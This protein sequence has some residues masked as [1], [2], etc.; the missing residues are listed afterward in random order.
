MNFCV[1]LL[2]CN[3]RNTTEKVIRSF[4]NNT[5]FDDLDF[6]VYA[7]GCTDEYIS[8]LKSIVHPSINKI[9]F[10]WIIKKENKGLTYALNELN[11]AVKD[12]EYSL[13][14]E[15]DWI[16]VTENKEWM[17]DSITFLET[18]KDVSTLFLRKWCSDGEKHIYGWNRTIE[19]FIHKNKGNFNY[20]NKMKDSE[21]FTVNSTI[22]QHIPEYLYSNNP[23]IHSNKDYYRTGIFPFIPHEDI[24]D[25][26]SDWDSSNS[27][28]KTTA[29]WGHSEAYSMEKHLGLKAYYVDNGVFAHYEDLILLNKPI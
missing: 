14:L 12:Y 11:E 6:Y 18:N 16:C 15:D 29:C 10:H 7:Q 26:F 23:N 17:N 1:T 8:E 3:N 25:S 19:Y 22:F 28:D 4:I 20:E 24:K 5:N 2:T 9:N 21:K 27:S 13:F